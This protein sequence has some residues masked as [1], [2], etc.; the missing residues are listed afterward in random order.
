M[1]RMQALALVVVC[2]LLAAAPRWLPDKKDPP[3]AR[4]TIYHVVPG[5]QLDFLKWMAAQ[6]EVAKE[7]GVPPIQLYAHLEGDSWDYL[8][9]GPVTTPEQDKKA[10]EV[11]VRR[12]LKVGL[13][14]ALEFRALVASHTDTFVAGPITAAELVAQAAR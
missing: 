10:D 13:P 11:A 4:I 1:K 3:R 2:G 8:G 12:G 7:A 5:R 9:M 14:A 6:E